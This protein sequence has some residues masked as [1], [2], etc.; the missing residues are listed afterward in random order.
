MLN[1]K[2]KQVILGLIEDMKISGDIV[3]VG[4]NNEFVY[5]YSGTEC[6]F[7][8]AW[9]LMFYEKTY[10]FGSTIKDTQQPI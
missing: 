1:D 4:A 7:S 3:S 10:I 9:L 8:T 5:L 2:S 6:N